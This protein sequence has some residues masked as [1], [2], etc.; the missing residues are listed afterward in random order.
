MIA[1][2]MFGSILGDTNG[3]GEGYLIT[4]NTGEQLVFQESA[5]W[6]NYIDMW[7]T[8]RTKELTCRWK[9]FTESTQPAMRHILDAV[10]NAP[11]R[12]RGV[13]VYLDEDPNL[14]TILEAIDYPIEICR[15]TDKLRTYSVFTGTVEEVG[16][17]LV[18]ESSRYINEL[19]V[20]LS[21]LPDAI[22]PHS[23]VTFVRTSADWR[24]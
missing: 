6:Y 9:A 18:G 21:S 10:K 1:P 20:E 2:G 17:E 4:T 7:R 23:V 14:R 16:N 19:M 22:P 11:V 8:R 12:G 15:L 5:A 13:V 24:K 3:G